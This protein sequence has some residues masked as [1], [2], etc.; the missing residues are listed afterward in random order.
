MHFA[1]EMPNCIVTYEETVELVD[2]GIA[3]DA[4]EAIA[5]GVFRAKKGGVFEEEAN[6]GEFLEEAGEER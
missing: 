5:R 3:E 2:V 1:C 4:P 6:V